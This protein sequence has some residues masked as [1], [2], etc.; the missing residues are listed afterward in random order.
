MPNPPPAVLIADSKGNL[1]ETNLSAEHLLGDKPARTC[2]ELLERQ[3]GTRDLPCDDNCSDLLV[4]RGVE[5][6]RR[7]RILLRA[8]RPP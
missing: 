6:A 2:R 4:S 8:S 3:G 7:T 1:I 5:R